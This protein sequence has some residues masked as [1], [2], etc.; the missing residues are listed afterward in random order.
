M[1]WGN[2]SNFNVAR[3]TRIQRQACKII[4]G[5]EYIDFESAKSSFKIHSFE[6]SVF[7]NIA[8]VMFKVANGLVPKYISIMYCTKRASHIHAQLSEI[9]YQ[10]KLSIH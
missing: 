2:A 10:M 8:K 5:N 9:A 6:Q 4:L 3:I 1:I 7:L